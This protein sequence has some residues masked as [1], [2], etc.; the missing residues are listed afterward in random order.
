MILLDTNVVSELMKLAPE[1]AVMVWINTLP[2]STVFIS[3]VTQ[4]EILYGVA[5]VPEGKR[6]EGLAQAARI[7]FETYFRGRI[8]PFDPEAAE[9]FAALA[10]GRRQVGRPISQAD[11]QIAAIARSRGADLATRNVA[12]FEGCGVEIV[13][14][15]GSSAKEPA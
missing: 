4:A 3:A 5:L 15:W 9:A 11:A 14:P 2:G 12:D 13:N 10:A 7:A 6:R 8:L 1:P